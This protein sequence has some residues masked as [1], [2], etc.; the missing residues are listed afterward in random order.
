MLENTNAKKEAPK[1]NLIGLGSVIT[2]EL[3]CNGDLRIDGTVN[4]DLKC[5][6]KLIMGPEAKIT[7]NINAKNAEIFCSIKGN[8]IVEELLIL[9]STALIKGNITTPKL[10]IEPGAIFNGYCTMGVFIK[11]DIVDTKT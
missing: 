8:L 1:I 10:S 9:K 3:N 2:G 5:S 4:G 11:D 6:G 7:G